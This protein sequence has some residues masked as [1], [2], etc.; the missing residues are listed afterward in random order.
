[1][2]NVS[3]RV[4][5]ETKKAMDEHEE[6]N[7]SAV[8]RNVIDT[9]LEEMQSKNVARAVATSERLSQTINPEDVATQNSADVIREHRNKR[10][11][12]S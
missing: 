12:D 3:V 5:D 4:D 1:M 2:G 6:I 11:G 7:W 9:H 8:I 10:Y